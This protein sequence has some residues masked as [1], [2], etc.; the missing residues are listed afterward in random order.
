MPGKNT[1]KEYRPEAFYHIYNRGVAKQNIFLDEADYKKFLGYLKLY[2][3]PFKIDDA[4][5]KIFP[6][7]R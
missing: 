2:L 4:S 7:R 5:V 1:I 6:S 3:T